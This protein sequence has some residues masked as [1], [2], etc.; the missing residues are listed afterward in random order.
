MQTVPHSLKV[1]P[2]PFTLCHSSS[3]HRRQTPCAH[4]ALPVD[5]AELALQWRLALRLPSQNLPSV[6][7]PAV[8][9]RTLLPVKSLMPGTRASEN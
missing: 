3:L 1:A 5:K 2:V 8:A 7:V 9:V 4:T 6:N